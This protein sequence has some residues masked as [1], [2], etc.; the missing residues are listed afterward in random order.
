MRY[1]TMSYTDIIPN[2]LYILYI[3][4]TAAP[5]FKV[6]LDF[7][8]MVGEE[9]DAYTA[10]PGILDDKLIVKLEAVLF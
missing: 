4:S 3:Y 6:Y 7:A 1:V 5:Y 10:W 2:M 8:L 9:S